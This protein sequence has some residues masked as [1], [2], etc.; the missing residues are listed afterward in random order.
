MTETPTVQGDIEF[1]ADID[2]AFATPSV[3]DRVGKMGIDEIY[4]RPDIDA[5]IADID[6]DLY[7]TDELG[8][9]GFEA[10]DREPTDAELVELFGDDFGDNSETYPDSPETIITSE[11][12]P[13]ISALA[14]DGLDRFED[15]STQEANDHTAATGDLL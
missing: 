9:D 2:G 12:D 8:L 6:E 7:G 4:Y 10:L 14:G 13:D 1:E 5:E 3:A 15:R 11:D